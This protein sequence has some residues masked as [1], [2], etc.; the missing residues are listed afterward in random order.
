MWMNCQ[1]NSITSLQHSRTR[2][3]ESLNS[4][5]AFQ[6]Q[7]LVQNSEQNLYSDYILNQQLFSDNSELSKI[8]YQFTIY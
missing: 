8:K 1:G 4:I 7:L 2:G 5:G 6:P 3:V